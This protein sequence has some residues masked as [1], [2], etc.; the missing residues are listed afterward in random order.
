[1]LTALIILIV[2]GIIVNNLTNTGVITTPADNQ[3]YCTAVGGSMQNGACLTC[4]PD[5]TCVIA[6][7]VGCSISS[8]NCELQGSSIVFLKVCNPF[9]L[10]L[11]GNFVGFVSSLFSSCGVSAAQA[12]EVLSVQS[13]YL[14]SILPYGSVNATD[15]GGVPGYYL[16]DSFVACN[17][18]SPTLDKVL[19]FPLNF[20]CFTVTGQWS[21]SSTD[22]Y[23]VNCEITD[24][25][26]TAYQLLAACYEYGPYIAGGMTVGEAWTVIP[27]PTLI[28]CPNGLA[29]NMNYYSATTLSQPAGSGGILSIFSG[30]FVGFV[31]A[32]IGGVLLLLLGFGIF[33]GAAT[34]EAG[35][36]PQG[37]KLAQSFGIALIIWGPLYSEFNTWF[38]SGWLPIG[39]DGVAGIVNVGL[40]ALFFIGV[41]LL[42]QGG[43][44]TSSTKAGM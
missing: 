27:P 9:T 5:D 3:V 28:S 37:S 10:L 29:P 7:P 42:S 11:T 18:T 12:Q 26:V 2:P 25:S 16:N 24:S 44:T 15:C 20:Y 38:V 30:N 35:S 40:M 6:T 22:H 21:V 34:V 8:S 36:N 17:V 31:M 1:M 39:L 4:T 14:Q 32:I 43:G 13:G 23:P 41:Y 19:T 33:A